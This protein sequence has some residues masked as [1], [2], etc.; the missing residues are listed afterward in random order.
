MVFA[1]FVIY[2]RFLRFPRF[3]LPD[4]SCICLRFSY[5]A[6]VCFLS[7]FPVSL[8]QPFHRCFP[9][10]F[11]FGLDACISFLA[12]VHASIDY[13]A[14][15]SFFSLLPDFPWQRFFQCLFSSFDSGTQLTAIPFSVSLFRLTVTTS[16]SQ[17]FPFGL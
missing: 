9:Y 8:P 17:L 2:F 11:A 3:F 4:F 7:S 6:S 10:A 5:L 14:L 13:S 16:T 12:S 15:C 1:A